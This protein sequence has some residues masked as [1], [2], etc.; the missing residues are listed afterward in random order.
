MKT[1]QS[2]RHGTILPLLA[3][4]CFALFGFVAL[5][6]DLGMLMVARTECQNAADAAALTGARTLDNNVPDGVTESAY[7]NQRPAA[8]VAATA[9]VRS[10][11][12]LQNTF[13]FSD[14]SVDKVEIG[15]YDYNTTTQVFQPTFPTS[16]ADP[17]IKMTN[18]G[19]VRPWTACRVTVKGD[20]PT[21]FARIFGITSMPMLARATSAH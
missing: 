6:V 18:N 5:A 4:T 16:T 20:Q 14:S 12:L 8:I 2:T 10:N 7:D 11:Y 9:T 21:Y 1:M 15:I 19:T 13:A 17:A 3:I